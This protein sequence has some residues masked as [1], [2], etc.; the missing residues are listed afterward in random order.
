MLK[1]FK[2]FKQKFGHNRK[3]PRISV[4]FYLFS[5]NLNCLLIHQILLACLC[6][7]SEI[8]L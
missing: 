6:L 5:D 2:V 3:A 4:L 7:L 1:K 8:R